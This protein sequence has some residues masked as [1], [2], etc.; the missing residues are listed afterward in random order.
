LPCPS[1]F[2]LETEKSKTTI[3][4]VSVDTGDDANILDAAAKGASSAIMLILNIAASLIAFKSF[5]AFLDAVI[6]WF[7]GFAGDPTF[8]F[9]DIL[10]YLFWPLSIMMGIVPEECSE[11]ARLIGMKLLVTEFPAFQDL[12]SIKAACAQ[13]PASEGCTLSPRSIS[14]A[15]FALCGF[16]NVAS[17]GMQVGVLGGLCPERKSTFAQVVSRAMISGCWVSFL[18]A[19]LAGALL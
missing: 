3:K 18:N 1:F 14:I 9:Q 8:S 13:D 12:G 6:M 5:V 11:V 16:A 2:Y 15:T 4:D 10:G 7:A 17:M 19:C